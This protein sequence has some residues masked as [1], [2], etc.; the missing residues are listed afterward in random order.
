VC[1][2]TKWKLDLRGLAPKPV[3][4][5]APMFKSSQYFGSDRAA[6]GRVLISSSLYNE[7]RKHRL[8]GIEFYPCRPT[9]QVSV[10][11]VQRNGHSS[12]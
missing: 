1:G 6:F 12:R 9:D 7:L 5:P 8:R 10:M 3:S 11:L 2:Q 4:I